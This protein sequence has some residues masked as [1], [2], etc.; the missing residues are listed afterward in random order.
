MKH[1]ED[2]FDF[3]RAAIADYY[4]KT[5]G[6]EIAEYDVFIVWFCKT[7]QNFKAIAATAE[8]DD[9]LFEVTWNGDKG[10]A[11]LDSYYKMQNKVIRPSDLWGKEK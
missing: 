8:K 2:F 10:E 5:W 3:V 1:T 7:L 9:R 6:I 11:Y 4:A